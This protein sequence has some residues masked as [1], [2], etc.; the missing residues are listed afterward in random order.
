MKTSA[1][2]ASRF[3]LIMCTSESS[4]NYIESPFY[5]LIRA[6]LLSSHDKEKKNFFS[7]CHC[8]AIR[9]ASARRSFII[10]WINSGKYL[11]NFDMNFII[12]ENFSPRCSSQLSLISCLLL[13][14]RFWV[15]F[16][17]L[18][19]HLSFITTFELCRIW[20]WKWKIFCFVVGKETLPPFFLARFPW[21]STEK[22]ISSLVEKYIRRL[23]P[24]N[25]IVKIL[26]YYSQVPPKRM[27][28]RL[29]SVTEKILFHRFYR[30]DDIDIRRRS[31]QR[32]RLEEEWTERF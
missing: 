32:L 31:V 21:S 24:V 28:L 26:S 5:S 15:D 17:E 10:L 14:G 19:S 6:E 22:H 16:R 30:Y 27:S 7:S 11:F 4:L 2:I 29:N 8:Y 25:I 12:R 23:S 20:R 3:G 13:C 9:S 18:Q 1:F